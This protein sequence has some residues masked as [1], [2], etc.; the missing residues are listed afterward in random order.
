M[1][2]ALTGCGRSNVVASSGVGIN[3][4]NFPDEK[5]RDYLLAQDYGSD[6]VLT[7]EEVKGIVHMD[8]AQ[9]G[10]GDLKG[11]K[12]FTSLMTLDC[13]R[14]GSLTAVDVAGCTA[15]QYVNCAECGVETLD[16]SGCTALR[17][18]DCSQNQLTTL[19]VSGCTTLNGLVCSGNALE[20]L[21]ATGCAALETLECS[22]NRLT[23]LDV[24]GCTVLALLYCNRNRLATLDVSDCP[25]LSKLECAGN[26]IKEENIKPKN[27]HE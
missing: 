9:K 3:A 12:H 5:F 11:I 26:E 19:D 21:N 27:E 4:E 13:R 17:Y 23:T 2:G 6:G 14:N 24:S 22:D 15:L 16:V 25:K 8:I 20:T 1:A 10:I 18:L 7:E